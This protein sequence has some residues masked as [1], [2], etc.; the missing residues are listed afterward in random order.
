MY[1]QVVTEKSVLKVD[2]QVAEKKLKRKDDKIASLEKTL[3]KLREHNSSLKKILMAVKSL[4]IRAPDENKVI[5]SNNVTGIPSSGR[6]VKPMRG[7][8]KEATPRGPQYVDKQAQLLNEI[9]NDSIF[10]I[11]ISS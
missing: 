11:N 2:F 10:S 4:K 5:E 7:G 9:I 3:N 8:R 1:H 6:I